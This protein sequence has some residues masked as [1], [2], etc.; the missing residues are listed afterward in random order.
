MACRTCS[1]WPCVCRLPGCRT[2]NP[3]PC[4]KSCA[5]ECHAAQPADTAALAQEIG[6]IDALINEVMVAHMHSDHGAIAGGLSSMRMRLRAL[7]QRV[8]AGDG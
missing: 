5:C 4:S 6:E 8:G 3:D 2:C 7:A 1:I